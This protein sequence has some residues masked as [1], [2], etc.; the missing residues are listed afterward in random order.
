MKLKKLIKSY[1]I[2][3]SILAHCLII[4]IAAYFLSERVTSHWR[5]PLVKRWVLGDI[6]KTDVYPLNYNDFES[7]PKGLWLKIH[8]Q[9]PGDRV[10]FVRQAHAGSGYDQRRNRLMIFGSN[11]HGEN[12]NNTIYSFDLNTFQW[13]EAYSSDKPGTYTVN[14]DGIPVAGIK[15]NHPWAMHTFGSVVYDEKNDNL[16]VASYPGHLAPDKYG[17]QLAPIW[18]SIKRQPTWVYGPESNNWRSY[19]GKSISFSP[20]A[21]AFDSDR[22]VVTGF[23]PYGIY[24]WNGIHMGWKKI[25]RKSVG[26]YHTNVIYDSKNHV[27]ILY[28]GNK[29]KNSIKV[30]VAGEKMT[31][32]MP[33]LGQRPPAGQSIPLVFHKQEGKVVALIDVDGYAQTWLYDYANDQW[34]RVESADFPYQIGMNYSME[35][36]VRNNLV[37]LVSSPKNEETA[38]WVLRL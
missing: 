33:T 23:L 21:I 20:Y 36:D 8:Q 13:L 10:R 17:Q 34:F 11:T 19:N 7:L 37:V 27:F 6:D 25:G 24:D 35:Y 28:G 15:H 1:F 26:E 22:S 9:R 14:D 12:W 5:W 32:T 30:F 29:M 3:A 38:V 16:V 4:V 2:S 31:E 18:T